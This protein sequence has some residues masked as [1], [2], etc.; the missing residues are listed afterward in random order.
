MNKNLSCTLSV[1]ISLESLIWN[2]KLYICMDLRLYITF[3]D[4]MFE[5][6]TSGFAIY[7]YS[8]L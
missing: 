6:A 5:L 7:I 3:L 8:H 2:L 4:Y 1:I